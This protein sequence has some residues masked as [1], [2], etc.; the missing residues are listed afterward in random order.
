[1][2]YC[3]LLEYMKKFVILIFLC[4]PINVLSQGWSFE[5]SIGYG[6]Y[7]LSDIKSIQH[8]MTGNYGL[9][10]TDFFP[11]HITHSFALGYIKER[12]YLGSN[13]S[14]ITTGG[15]LH[16]AD[17]SGSYTV[18]IIMNGYRI[19]I[20]YRHFIN[21][22]FSSLSLYLQVSPGILFSRFKLNEQVD[23]YSKS[24]Q[25]NTEMK[26]FGLYLEPTI[27]V[28]YN[29]SNYLQF[30]LG[31][32]YE[33]DFHNK[34]KYSGKETDIKALWNGFRLYGGLLFVLPQ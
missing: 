11:N 9:K 24:A 1:M 18:D 23:I 16:R 7:Q 3:W 6:S 20:F 12:N 10:A 22:R 25:E 5:Y 33:V 30:S 4:F 13:F 8:S 19:G 26:G 14:Y 2:K 21:T 31:G 29:F 15:R 27:G 17:Y 32:G 34:M 28:K